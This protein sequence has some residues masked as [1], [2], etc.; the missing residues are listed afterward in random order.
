MDWYRSIFVGLCTG[1]TYG[2][3]QLIVGKLFKNGSNK[4]AATTLLVFLL[5]L[6]ALTFLSREYKLFTILDSW[7]VDRMLPSL[8]E[9]KPRF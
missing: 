1:L 6:G 7:R 9:K 8:I 2:L 4:K 3:A 5:I